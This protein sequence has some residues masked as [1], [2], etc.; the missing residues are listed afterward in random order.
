MTCLLFFRVETCCRH[1]RDRE[2]NSQQSLHS[3]RHSTISQ[4]LLSSSPPSF[5]A[6][7]PLAD[8][9]W[10]HLSALRPIRQLD[11]SLLEMPWARSRPEVSVRGTT[12]WLVT[13]GKGLRQ[14]EGEKIKNT[15]SNQKNKQRRAAEDRQEV[16]VRE[17]ESQEDKK[18]ERLRFK[19]CCCRW[20]SVTFEPLEEAH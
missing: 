2:R 1:L 16:D 6:A 13:R 19:L 18:R 5:I 11:A 3:D 12:G 9:I 4:T 8:L 10:G 17:R 20:R 7:P 15:N 14:R